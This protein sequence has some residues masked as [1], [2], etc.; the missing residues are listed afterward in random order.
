M[1]EV[2]ADV[3]HLLAGGGVDIGQELGGQHLLLSLGSVAQH[4]LG[5]VL[6]L[7][8]YRLES[9]LELMA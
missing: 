6:F 8:R 7:L 3:G 2:E 9:R 4:E 1:S 5:R